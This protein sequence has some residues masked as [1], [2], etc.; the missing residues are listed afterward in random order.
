MSE[1]HSMRLN[2]KCAHCGEP[3]TRFR[4]QTNLCTIHYRIK[5]MKEDARIDG[6][7][8][9]S[10]ELLER[11]LM[12]TVLALRARNAKDQW[13]KKDNGCAS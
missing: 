2:P 8:E 9:P 6:K 1:F 5:Q 10:R 4:N 3:A 7:T 13:Q 12:Q 11:L